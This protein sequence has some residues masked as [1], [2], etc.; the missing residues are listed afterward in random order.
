MPKIGLNKV[1]N[2][3]LPTKFPT[4]IKEILLLQL[5]TLKKI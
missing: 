4:H 5:A 1:L 2:K 3:P